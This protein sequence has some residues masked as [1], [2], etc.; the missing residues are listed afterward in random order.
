MLLRLSFVICMFV[1]VDVKAAVGTDVVLL[2]PRFEAV[3][4][5]VMFA[6]EEEHLIS[7][8]VRL[9]ADGADAVRV[10]LDHRLDRD[11][12]EYLLSHPELFLFLLVHVLIVELLEGTYVHAFYRRLR[13]TATTVVISILVLVMIFEDS[14]PFIVPVDEVQVVLARRVHLHWLVFLYIK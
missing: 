7:V 12:L 1:S 6:A 2:E 3:D 10:L 4:M 14:L 8:H 11:L 13:V 5:K 9:E